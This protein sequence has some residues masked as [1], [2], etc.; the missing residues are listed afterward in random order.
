M[1]I[2][3]SYE[4]NYDTNLVLRFRREA[5]SY[6][7]GFKFTENSVLNNTMLSHVRQTFST[8]RLLKKCNSDSSLVSLSSAWE[9]KNHKI[10]ILYANNVSFYF[11]FR[12][13]VNQTSS[14]LWAA[15]HGLECADVPML[16]WLPISPKIVLFATLLFKTPSVV[17]AGFG[18]WWRRAN[19]ANFIS[20]ISLFRL[21]W[22][23]RGGIN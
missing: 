11:F 15:R 7:F 3:F 12:F 8:S 14:C 18:Y 9:G 22:E 19:D 16:P 4:W 5:Y 20:T 2:Q 1:Q 6:S 23:A 10:R 17:G 21:H 13:S